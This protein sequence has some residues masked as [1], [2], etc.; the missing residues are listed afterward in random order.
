MSEH[1]PHETIPGDSCTVHNEHRPKPL[2][3]VH[4][5]IWPQEFGGPT[6]PE[7]LVWICDTGHY[8]VHAIL[9]EL[10]KTGNL[11]NLAS[12]PG[13]TSEKALAVLGFNRI[14]NQAI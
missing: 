5:H 6:V 14:L 11:G 8:N 13:G 7:N 3:T 9:A 1:T 12:L 2:R 10:V 4:H